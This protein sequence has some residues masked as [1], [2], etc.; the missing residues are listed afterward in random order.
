VESVKRNKRSFFVT[1][2][3]YCCVGTANSLSIGDM[4][5][6]MVITRLFA[7]SVTMISI[8]TLMV[9]RYLNK[10]NEVRRSYYTTSQ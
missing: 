5:V 2:V 10:E 1:D 8:L 7:A 3:M 4:A 6:V 9:E